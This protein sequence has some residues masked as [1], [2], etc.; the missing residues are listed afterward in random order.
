M[1]KIL[2]AA[3]LFGASFTVQAEHSIVTKKVEKTDCK[4]IAADDYADVL[5][6]LKGRASEEVKL[7][8]ALKGLK[9]G[10]VDLD[11]LSEIMDLLRT[12]EGKLA[13]AKEAYSRCSDQENFLEIVQEKFSDAKSVE[14][15]NGHITVLK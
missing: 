3:V 5:S 11:Q 1:K 15:L 4:P 13:F 9:K 7:K 12:E 8:A 14:E 6:V 2:I 10:C